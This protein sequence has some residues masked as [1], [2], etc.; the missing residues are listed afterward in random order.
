MSLRGTVP[1]CDY[2]GVS[3]Q[4]YEQGE[5]SQHDLRLSCESRWIEHGLHVVL[6]ESTAVPRLPTEPPKRVLERRQRTDPAAVLDEYT[7]GRGWNVEKRQPW[8]AQHQ[9]SAQHY[10]QHER[11]MTCQDEICESAVDQALGT[12]DNSVPLKAGPAAASKVIRSTSWSKRGS[13]RSES[14]SGCTRR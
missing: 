13:S 11:E 14:A 6:N 7:P 5:S 4:V 12:D 3:S 10:E 2:H 9:Q 8:P 1:L